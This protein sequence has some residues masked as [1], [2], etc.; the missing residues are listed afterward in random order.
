MKNFST[1]HVCKYVWNGNLFREQTNT[2]CSSTGSN[3]VAVR[4]LRSSNPILNG[5]IAVASNGT[6]RPLFAIFKGQPMENIENN[7]YN[8]LPN[9]VIGRCQ[10]KS[11]VNQREMRIRLKRFGIYTYK[12]L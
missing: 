8:I 3:T 1:E 2:F 4:G 6:K 7:L 11:W 12:T 9:G 10:S 5:Y